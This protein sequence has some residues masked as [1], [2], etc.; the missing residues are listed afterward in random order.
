MYEIL[1]KINEPKDLKNLKIDE[2]KL[3]ANDIR[4]ALFYRLTRKAGHFGS[5]FGAVELEIAMHYV[6]DSPNDKFVFDVS[7]QAYPHKILTGRKEAFTD[8]NKFKTITGYTDPLESEHDIFNIGH[9]STAI[10]LASG[11]AKSRDLNDEKFNVIAVVGDGSLSGGEALEGLNVVGS[12]LKSNFI[13][14]LNDNDQFISESHGALSEH[15]KELRN[16]KG[17]LQNNLFKCLGYEYIYEENG[18]DIESL[19]DLFKKVKDIN[20]PVVLHIHTIKGCGYDIAVKNEELW[21][22]SEPFNRDNGEAKN[23]YTD[24]TYFTVLNNYIMDRAKSDDK[25]LLINPSYAMCAELTYEQRQVLGKKYI[26]VGIAEEHAV[27]MASGA[28]KNGTNVLLMLDASFVLRA[29]DQIIQDLS[30]NNNP[31]TILVHYSSVGCEDKTHLGIFTAPIYANVPNMIVLAPTC[32]KELVA[33]LESSLNQKEHPTMIFVPRGDVSY[34]DV[35]TNFTYGKF[36]VENKGSEIAIIAVA[37]MFDKG[38]NLVKDIKKEM[39]I[40]TTLINPRF[41]SGIDKETLNM[42]KNNHKL[43]ITLEDNSKYGGFGEKIAEYYGDSNIRVKTFGLE[44]MFYDE[45]DQEKVFKE[46]NLTNEKILEEIK[47]IYKSI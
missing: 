11:L 43:I 33:M 27:A 36:L 29:L 16:A 23:V 21:H 15:L 26:D 12:E 5:N 46:Y 28:A 14:V 31:A 17:N 13:V 3:L 30:L 39:N 20:H 37:A 10:S 41:V 40:D 8:E 32:K 4:E 42:L 47:T 9:T 24:E 18:N 2:L 35:D 7:H 19:I 6:F 45:Y 44:K 1:N 38:Y 25:F 34:R 22:W